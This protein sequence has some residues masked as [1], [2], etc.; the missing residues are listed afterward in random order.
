[1]QL[2]A[3]AFPVK[4]VAII[5]SIIFAVLLV[6]GGPIWYFTTDQSVTSAA[7]RKQAAL[8]AQGEVAV[9]TLGDCTLKIRESFGIADAQS[10]RINSIIADAVRGRYDGDTS[11]N[12]GGGEFFSAIREAYPNI[13]LSA[14][15]DAQSIAVGC[16]E[17]FKQQQIKTQSMIA[18]FKA[19]K[20]GSWKNRTFASEFPND[21]FTVRKGDATLR[22]IEALDHL[23]RVIVPSTANDATDTGEIEAESFGDNS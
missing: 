16:R 11:A 2:D 1:M 13:D 3:S 19:W 18:D 22:G 5:A 8:S 6:V 17:D 23:S 4:K 14:F 9:A 21:N 10:E 12:P 7:E 15:N 20:R